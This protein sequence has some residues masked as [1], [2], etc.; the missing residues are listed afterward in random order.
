MIHPSLPVRRGPLWA[1]AVLALLSTP[2]AAQ[3]SLGVRTEPGT[4]VVAVEV[5]VG[6][7]PAEEPEGQAG[8]AY[9]SARVAAAP[10][11][12]ILDSLGAR[13][14]VQAHKDA[15]GFT[16][17][18]AP[19]VWEETA[20]LVLL[21]LFRDPADPEAVQRERGAILAELAARATNPADAAAREADAAAFGP[22]HPWGRP[23]VGEREAVEKLGP[24]EVDVFIRAH[25]VPERTVVAV[26]G[27]VDAGD[28][29][30]RLLPLFQGARPRPP[31]VPPREPVEPVVR[32]DYN[33]ITTWVVA[34]YAVAPDADL[35]A[36]HLLAD[37]AREALSPGPRR[38]SVYNARSEVLR[39]ADGGEMRFQLVVPPG[40][41]EGWAERIRAA[42]THLAEAPLPQPVFAARLRRH[43]GERLRGLSSPEARARAVARDLLLGG[44]GTGPLVALEGL[45]PERL[46]QA[47]KS[48]DAPVVVFLGPFLEES[49]SR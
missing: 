11:R 43:R 28:A 4:P 48:L 30:A 34:S 1:L 8:I 35:P 37:L 13:L 33:S 2:L 12:P 36:L 41:A 49:E 27:P 39:R 17:I 23:A 22:G 18:A 44:T 7:G 46:H 29:E 21:A 5:L 26:V 15:L 16:L 10:I 40:E 6:A 20:R 31:E 45:T 42:V 14:D 19:D 9:L 32:R 3:R 38:H 47:A 24:G 25:F